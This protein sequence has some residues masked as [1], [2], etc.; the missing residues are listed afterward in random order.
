VTANKARRRWKAYAEAIE[1]EIDRRE[2]VRH[3][4]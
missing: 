2:E 1:A 4:S 3:R